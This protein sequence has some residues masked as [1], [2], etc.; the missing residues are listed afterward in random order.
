[1]IKSSTPFK[2]HIQ[3]LK[4]RIDAYLDH[5]MPPA[6]TPP[7]RLHEAMRYIVFNGG[8]R[9]R[10]LL[11]YLTGELFK[12]ELEPLDPLAATIEWIHCY[13][14]THDDLPA[15][16]NDDYRRGQLSA[17]KAYDEAT[18]I[19]AGN[20]LQNLAFALLAEK[21]Q[22]LIGVFARAVGSTGLLGGQQLDLIAKKKKPCLSELQ[23]IALLKTATLFEVSM[24]LAARVCHCFD[25]QQLQYIKQLGQSIGLAY[26]IQ[27]DYLDQEYHIPMKILRS[28]LQ[29]ISHLLDQLTGNTQRLREFCFSFIKT[30]T[31]IKS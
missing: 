2:L 10:P 16:D 31:A 7:Q 11:V 29:T 9:I 8:K 12:G 19:L 30:P 20:A 14:L 3:Q 22:N 27:D 5:H 21:H 1:M 24:E 4:S 6:D 17:H 18:A 23:N 28:L 25:L 13:S 26:Q 15:M